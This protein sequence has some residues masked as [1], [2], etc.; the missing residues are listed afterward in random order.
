MTSVLDQKSA[1]PKSSRAEVHS[2]RSELLLNP[3][4]MTRL[5]LKPTRIQT[6]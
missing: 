5:K 2:N 3:K 4:H 1:D 6:E